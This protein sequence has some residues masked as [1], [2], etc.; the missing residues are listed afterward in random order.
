M[1]T[2]NGGSFSPDH[3]ILEHTLSRPKNKPV[4]TGGVQIGDSAYLDSARL[5]TLTVNR[6]LIY[7]DGRI[8]T[9]KGV[10]KA[11]YLFNAMSSALGS[12][13]LA[14]QALQLLGQGLTKP[15]LD[16]VSMH[17][18]LTFK[19]GSSSRIFSTHVLSPIGEGKKYNLET[20]ENGF[21]LTNEEL[22]TK[23]A[24]KNPIDDPNK[25]YFKIRTVV[26]GP[27]TALKDGLANEM[28]FLT[29]YTEEY[30]DRE[31]ALGAQYATKS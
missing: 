3:L 5:G 18:G 21:T 24:F 23:T 20:T 9:G 6:R 4:G 17:K 16:E 30:T 11:D 22:V 15:V 12:S 31:S 1:S 27:L 8:P 2:V 29:E 7:A 19:E 13:I 25:T 10:E 26:S 28:S 14:S